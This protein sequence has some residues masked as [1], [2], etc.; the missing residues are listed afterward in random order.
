MRICKK[1]AVTIPLFI[2]LLLNTQNTFAQTPFG[3]NIKWLSGYEKKISGQ[4]I[5]YFSAF[6]DYVNEA[7]L[8]RATDGK[9][10]IEW[11]TAVVPI[12]GKNRYTYFRWVAAHST[13]SSGGNRKFD[14]YI[15][16]DKVLTITTHPG[17]KNPVWSFTANDSTQIIFTQLRSD[18][19]RDAHG[20]AYLRVPASRIIPGKA[21]RLKLVGQ[22]EQ[23][24]DW[25]MT[26]QYAFKE[27]ADLTSLPFLLKDGKQPLAL[28]VLHFGKKE[29][30]YVTVNKKKNFSFL[31]KE[32]MNHFDI[33][34]TAAKKKDSVYV[35]VKYGDTVLSNGYVLMEPVIKREIDF[36][37]HSHTDIGYSYLQPEVEKI[38]IKDIYDALRMIEKTKN[39]PAAS[40]FKWNVESLWAVENF[41]KQASHSDSVRFFNAVKNGSIGLS[42]F[43]ANML[44]GLSMPEEMFHYTEY[45]EM[46]RKKFHLPIESAM[47][48]DVPGL[49]WATVT[50]FAK[51]GIRYLSDGPNYTGKNSPYLGDRVGYF[52]KTW[53]DK[54]V[55]WESPSGKEKILLWTAA[56]G[57]SSWHGT[58]AGGI[59]L[60]G[61]K[62]I[63]GY[64]NDLAAEQ[65]P[66]KMIQW[67]YNIVADN[68]PVDT[69]I[70]DFVKQWNEKYQSPKIVLTTINKMF[71]EFQSRNGDNLPVVKGDIT[72]YWEDGAASTAYSEGVNRLNSLRCQELTTLYAMLAPK[73]YNTHDFYQ[74]WR[75]IMMFT[76]HTWGAFNS[77]SDPDLPFVTE[78]WQIK[79]NFMLDA[80]KEINTLTDELLQPLTDTTSKKIAVINTLSWPRGGAVYLPSAIDANVI[81][82][83]NGKTF[84]L[85]KL[86][87]GRK[88]FIAENIRPLSV[89]YFYLKNNAQPQIQKNP[90]TIT[91]SSVSNGKIF[92]A[93]NTTNGSITKLVKDGYNFSGDFKNQGLNGYWYVP[94]L[95]P[96]DA[97]TNDAVKINVVEQGPD[98]VT[99]TIRSSAPGTESLVRKISLFA[100]DDKIL[101][102]D[103]IDKKAIRT[104]EGVYFSF[105]FTDDLKKTTIDVGYGTMQYLK[106]QLPG[107]NMDFLCTRRWLD[108]SDNNKGIQ[109]I[110][111]E[112]FMTAPD[113]MVDET[114]GFNQSVKV[115]RADGKPTS[116]WFSYVINNYWHTNYKAD[117]QGISHYH[118]AI[119]PHGVLQN[120]DQEKSAMEFTQPLIAFPVNENTTLPQNLFRLSNDK[121]VITSI[122]PQTDV[123]FM[124]RLFNPEA[125][126]Q[127]T[128]FIWNQFKPKNI[129]E[130]SS[131]KSISPHSQITVS[132]F[133][134]VDLIVK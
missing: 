5:S 99:I 50:G 31:L 65:Y 38:H 108:A 97:V 78:Q 27:K 21:L 3:K 114:L 53:G 77:I 56:K 120:V 80:N 112:P 92:V 133:D 67:R 134:V 125:I 58:P 18:G 25:F 61:P 37:H 119:R 36:I 24:N 68:G 60:S 102:D 43:Y 49:A 39:Y 20:I 127:T 64:L 132:G 33:A 19:A 46:L 82:D 83:A 116:T 74:A 52:V 35:L 51:G 86:S 40:K 69:T 29:K 73:K 110:M 100:N 91:D 90:F 55:W 11:E 115:W 32:G 81:T 94:G 122:T 70:S 107:S 87:D 76:E 8:T 12:N 63:A 131:K 79:K 47:I 44:T 109:L 113:S 9:K 85:Q 62:K 117:Q 104:K 6:P 45:A 59:F 41:L 106:D 54:P 129:I 123:G 118:Y 121:I 95:N 105:P 48:S 93:W 14:L 13:G 28:T 66:Y 42:G 84:P 1:T 7:L 101:L 15:N 4:D 17:N 124:I 130:A 128:S 103:V 96:A 30:I 26:F 16:G 10:V 71:E 34:V 2:F 23:S 57:Y 126:S 75:N 111:I 88:I 22:A 89:S 98:L 72:P